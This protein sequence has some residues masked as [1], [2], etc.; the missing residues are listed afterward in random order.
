MEKYPYW[1]I[2]FW[3][4][5]RTVVAVILTAMLAILTTQLALVSATTMTLAIFIKVITAVFTACV[6]AMLYGIISGV[7]VVIGKVVRDYFSGGDPNQPIQK[8][9]L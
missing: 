7:F 9:P 6:N 1:K 3:R 5:I 2:L 8:M 4:F